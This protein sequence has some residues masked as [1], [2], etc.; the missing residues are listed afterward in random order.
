[1]SNIQLWQGSEGEFIPNNISNAEELVPYATSLSQKQQLHIISAFQIEAY[2]M[3][4]EFAWKKAMTK[5]KET[6][7]TLGMRF[8]GELLNREDID[9]YSTIDSSLTDYSSIVLAEQLGVISST[10][11]LKL[12]HSNELITHYFSSSTNEEL[13][14]L[15][16]MQIVKSSIQYVLYEEDISIAI[17]FS[18]FRDRLLSE[19]LSMSDPQVDQVVGSPVFYL[20]TVI[21]ILTSAIKSEQGAKL[22]H[23]LANLNLILP[24]IWKNLSENDRWN[25]GTTYRD[26]TA[27]GN[28]MASS[29]VKN[30][31][32]KVKGF[33]Y[34][35]E[36]LRSVTFQR[37]AKV[38]IET[39]FAFNNFY[40]EPA[41]VKRLANLG[42]TI[43]T[44]ALLSCI[45]AYLTVYLG[46][47]YGV[48]NIAASIAEDKLKEIPFDRWKYYL[49][50]GIQ[51]D[52]IILQ[53]LVAKIRISKLKNLFE[54]LE[55]TDLEDLPKLNQDL[56]NSILR[57]NETRV[58]NISDNMLK[59]LK[60]KS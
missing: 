25:I 57:S 45:Q 60:S 24:H 29:G 32:L 8:V 13:D 23:A 14:K 3:A 34:V 55:L 27:S 15:S 40:N 22:E 31:L 2:D 38:V 35:P 5:L 52:E 1:M 53:K 59:I 30:A 44:P 41:A 11:A 26:V 18:N 42:S 4:A 9:E 12:R 16:A 37:S 56:I 6:I 10:A 49:Q 17:E 21:T 7:S 33:D 46:N 28:T 43:P 20:R 19:S 39:H 51:S 47:Y 48:S 50:R 36:N 54:E 58:S